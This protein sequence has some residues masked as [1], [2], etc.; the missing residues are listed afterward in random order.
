MGQKKRGWK[1]IFEE[2]FGHCRLSRL[3]PGVEVNM[4]LDDMTA[5]LRKVLHCVTTW[6]DFCERVR[7][8]VTRSTAPSEESGYETD[9]ADLLYVALF[10]E[11]EHVPSSK[12]PNQREK[13]QNGPPPFDA[14]FP[15]GPTC[16]IP[17]EHAGGKTFGAR[18]MATPAVRRAVTELSCAVMADCV[19]ASGGCLKLL[20]SGGM[21]GKIAVR[22]GITVTSKLSDGEYYNSN[23]KDDERRLAV[24]QNV[25]VC[26]T[27]EGRAD[28][29][30]SDTDQ[31]GESDLKIPFFVTRENRENVYVISNDFDVVCI[32]LLRMRD[33]ID[34]VT[35][36][37]QFRI[38]VDTASRA[39]DVDCLVD[40]SELWRSILRYFRKHHPTVRYPVETLVLLVLFTGSDFTQGFSRLG[41]A[42]VWKNFSEGGCEV[43]CPKGD[44]GDLPPEG[45]LLC[46][47]RFYG[48]PSKIH[49]T[50]TAEAMLYDFLT[51]NYNRQIRTKVRRLTE[52][53]TMQEL[54]TIAASIN[55]THSTA[56]EW[57]QLPDDDGAYAI[58]RR[59]WWTMEYWI[60]GH[61]STSPFPDPLRTD[62]FTQLPVHGWVRSADGGT[63]NAR[64]VHIVMY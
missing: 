20:V 30:F 5:G 4:I 52:C 32:L 49:K 40:V 9:P 21:A 15:V 57:W 13:K 6:D 24:P 31:I 45:V 26:W 39:K 19:S 46:G 48:D 59:M 18:V 22:P 35:K 23:Q 58:F 10:D 8:R 55:R 51:F 36:E 50:Q 37:I 44:G 38:F 54:R 29:F 61:K 7:V 53:S 64:K 42:T 41:P 33:W 16:E 43:L 25:T 11:G 12:A 27:G 34:P 28:A 63:E 62:P 47:D 60:N 3:P 17:R 2:C 14:P 1:A 56:T